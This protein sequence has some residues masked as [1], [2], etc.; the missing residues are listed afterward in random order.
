MQIFSVL[1]FVQKGEVY[2]K[3]GQVAGNLR[4]H[5]GWMRQEFANELGARRGREKEIMGYGPLG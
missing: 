3:S 5:H 4:R 1:F 2:Y